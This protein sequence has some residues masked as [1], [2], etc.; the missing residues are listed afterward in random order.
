MHRGD[1]SRATG[2][3]VVLTAEHDRRIVADIV[4]EW[5]RRHGQP[6]TLTLTG[7][8]GGSYAAGGGD[9]QIQL[10]VIEFCRMVSGRVQGTGLLTTAVPF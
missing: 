5:A 6:F 10:D 7:P 4:S 1:I 9:E 2:R 3:D 8:A